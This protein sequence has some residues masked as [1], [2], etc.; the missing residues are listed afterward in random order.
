MYL[1]SEDNDSKGCD[2]IL[3]EVDVG[4]DIPH[5]GPVPIISVEDEDDVDSS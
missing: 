4:D 1:E 3:K 2:D 5:I